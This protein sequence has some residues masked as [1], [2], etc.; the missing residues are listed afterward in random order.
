[1]K[2]KIIVIFGGVYSSLGK[3]IVASSIG[4]ILS[5]LGF[6]V[7]MQ[8]MDPYLNVNAGV[9]SPYQHGETFVT[10]DGHEADLDFG[11]YERFI[12]TTSKCG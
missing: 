4:A 10:K 12:R 3:G 1:M 9:L 7:Q 5:R 6:K 2:T 11:N 8:K